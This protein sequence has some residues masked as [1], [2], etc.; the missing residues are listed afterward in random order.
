MK[1]SNAIICRSIF[2]M[3]ATGDGVEEA[4]AGQMGG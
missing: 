1:I 2:P 4:V 3:E